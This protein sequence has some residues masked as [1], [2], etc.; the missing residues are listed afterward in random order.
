MRISFRGEPCD[1]APIRRAMRAAVKPYALPADA[2]ITVAF[3]DVD[4]GGVAGEAPGGLRCER[5]AVVE[6]AAALPVAR[7]HLLVELGP[8]RRRRGALLPRRRW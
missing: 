1:L 4:E 5:G 6:H 3:V 7:Q 2:R 8:G